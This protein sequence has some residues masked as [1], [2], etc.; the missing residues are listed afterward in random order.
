MTLYSV[1]MPISAILVVL[2]HPA[3]LHVVLAQRPDYKIKPF[4]VGRLFYIGHTANMTRALNRFP[5]IVSATDKI[6]QYV[7]LIEE[8][9]HERLQKN[10]PPS[11]AEPF[12]LCSHPTM[13]WTRTVHQVY[14]L[15]GWP[16]PDTSCVTNVH[17]LEYD[18]FTVEEMYD[19]MYTRLSTFKK[20]VDV[21]AKATLANLTQADIVLDCPYRKGFARCVL[22]P[23]MLIR[24]G[25]HWY[26]G[27]SITS[28]PKE[29]QLPNF[30]RN[31]MNEYSRVDRGQ[32][33]DTLKM[34]MPVRDTVPLVHRSDTTTMLET[35]RSR[36]NPSEFGIHPVET[37]IA[38]QDSLERMEVSVQQVE[39]ATTPSNIAII[40]LPLVLTLAPIAFFADV[41]TNFFFAYMLL[42]DIL[43][44][45][46]MAIKGVE[47]VLIGTSV[48]RSV[49]IRITSP[50][51]YKDLDA[52][53]AEIWAAE[54][55]TANSVKYMGI[56]FIVTSIVFLIIGV[57]L[58]FVALH[59]SRKM[60]KGKKKGHSP[61]SSLESRGS[62]L[63]PLHPHAD[64]KKSAKSESIVRAMSNDSNQEAMPLKQ[65]SRG[66][67][68]E[69][70]IERLNTV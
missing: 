26:I 43:T 17:N 24:V 32:L 27:N 6:L 56:A 60:R 66:S 9:V 68:R 34:R 13:E 36:A 3:I 49:A 52:A 19:A 51:P 4:Q 28:H 41:G 11:E 40:A 29:W 70:N 5:A 50:S 38:V 63:Q 14:G 46:P 39:D 48:Y 54:C 23:T 44:S 22:H 18:G 64:A 21:I 57:S 42:S 31:K 45:V 37:N 69:S 7:T 61:S 20:N 10:V 47:L 59:Y 12:Y 33:N 55:K 65:S 62:D 15:R 8:S 58:E 30:G 53:A 2:I 35:W 1:R 67:L 16:D 25:A